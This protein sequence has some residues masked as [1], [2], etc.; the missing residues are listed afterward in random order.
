MNLYGVYTVF[1]SVMLTSGNKVFA[2]I[3]PFKKIRLRRFG[4]L[5]SFPVAVTKYS[6]KQ[7]KR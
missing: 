5:V 7:L 3:S 4:V 6:E 1:L 2:N